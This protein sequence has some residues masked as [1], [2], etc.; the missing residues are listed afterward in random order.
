MLLE[1]RCLAVHAAIEGDWDF[2]GSSGEE[3]PLGMVQPS[4]SDVM[5]TSRLVSV[6][7]VLVEGFCDAVAK[8]AANPPATTSSTSAAPHALI[9][10][11]RTDIVNRRRLGA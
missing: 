10:S 5:R 2:Y 7:V 9:V 3:F 1:P 4:S 6:T 8:S 11:P